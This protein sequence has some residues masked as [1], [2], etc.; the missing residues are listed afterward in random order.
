MPLS[1]QSLNK[2]WG[3]IILTGLLLLA[4]GFWWLCTQRDSI[5]FLPAHPGA[6]W[7]ID[8]KAT[9]LKALA[10]TPAQVTFKRNLIL[11]QVPAVSTITI[12]VFKSATV[13]VNDHLVEGLNLE[14]KHWKRLY[15]SRLSSHWL[16][17][18]ERMRSG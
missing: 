14:G 2:A 9:D 8:A 12:C 4:G 6:R 15:H 1:T 3:F 5:A 18:W 11:D 16:R 13:S 17:V 7:I 10:A